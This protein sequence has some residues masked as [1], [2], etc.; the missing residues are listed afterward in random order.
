MLRDPAVQNPF[1]WSDHSFLLLQ[2][3]LLYFPG[4]H[5]KSV[6]Q[7]IDSAS[8]QKHIAEY[9][10]L[11]RKLSRKTV[12]AI[13]HGVQVLAIATLPD[14]KSV[15][16]DVTMMC[17]L[18]AIESS[19]FWLTQPFLGDYYKTYGKGTNN[20]KTIVSFHYLRSHRIY[21]DPLHS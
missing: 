3:D 12:V 5:D 15:L 17:L 21:I 2:F 1:S 7:I 13:Y 6:R 18:G 19:I 8:L 4:G 14:G 9:F 10:P 11:T 16:H 20:V